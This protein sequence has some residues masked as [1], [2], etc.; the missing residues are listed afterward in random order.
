MRLAAFHLEQ[1][2]NYSLI[3]INFCSSIG[4]PASFVSEWGERSKLSPNDASVIHCDLLSERE[5]RIFVSKKKLSII[6]VLIDVNC[7]KNNFG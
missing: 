1:K 3:F 5:S 2:H 6:V 7:L 4:A